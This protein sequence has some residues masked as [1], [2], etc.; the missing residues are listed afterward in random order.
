MGEAAVQREHHSE[1]QNKNRQADS[2]DYLMRRGQPGNDCK[3]DEHGGQHTSR[4]NLENALVPCAWVCT[5]GT[6]HINDQR[7][8]VWRAGKEDGVDQHFQALNQTFYVTLIGMVI[9]SDKSNVPLEVKNRVYRPLGLEVSLLTRKR[10]LLKVS[11]ACWNIESLNDNKHYH[12]SPFAEPS[13]ACR[14]Y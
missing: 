5:A 7:R 2:G 4:D 6:L 13:D 12:A 9:E 14:L 1:H 8:G 10:S 3:H 11:K